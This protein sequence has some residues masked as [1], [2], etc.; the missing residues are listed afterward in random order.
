M[1]VAEEL[2]Q[3]GPGTRS[4]GIEVFGAECAR[5]ELAAVKAARL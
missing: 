5:K 1:C 3:F 2:G 4:I